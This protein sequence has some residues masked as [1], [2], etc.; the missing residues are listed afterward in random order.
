M[1]PMYG[2]SNR[3][4][5]CDNFSLLFTSSPASAS[6][7]GHNNEMATSKEL[8]TIA[9][10]VAGCIGAFKT[11]SA[12]TPGEALDYSEKARWKIKDEFSRF[13]VWSGNIGAHQK[14]RSSL[15]Y[16]LRDASHLVSQVKTL[17]V[18]LKTLLDTGIFF[19]LLL[20]RPYTWHELTE[21]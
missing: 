16:R 7:L 11:V 15:D 20:Y 17:L 6:S 3:A 19:L 21:P 12:V 8:A 13:K 14:G 2:S 10:H 4:K 5:D 1:G 18:D 9:D